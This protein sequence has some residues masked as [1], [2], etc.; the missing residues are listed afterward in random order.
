MFIIFDLGN[1]DRHF[2]LINTFKPTKNKWHAI[3]SQFVFFIISNSSNTKNNGK[4]NVYFFDAFFFFQIIIVITF[5][6]LATSL[7]LNLLMEKHA[8]KNKQINH[9][10]F[11]LIPKFNIIPNE[12]ITY[13]KNREQIQLT[14]RLS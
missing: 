4:K 13:K 7:C 9:L 6:K 3:Y 8:T 11:L 10:T 2:N 12:L 14:R 1:T 5:H